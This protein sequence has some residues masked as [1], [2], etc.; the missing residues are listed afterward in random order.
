[1][2]TFGLRLPRERDRLKLQNGTSIP[3]ALV[4]YRT[5]ECR[6]CDHDFTCRKVKGRGHAASPAI[7]IRKVEKILSAVNAITLAHKACAAGTAIKT[8]RKD[9][10]VG[11]RH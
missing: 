2:R 1:M 11:I 10:Q 9:D 7:A 8:E 5:T 3:S 6:I 4:K